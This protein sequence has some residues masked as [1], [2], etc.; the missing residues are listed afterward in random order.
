MIPILGRP[1][2]VATNSGGVLPFVCGGSTGDRAKSAWQ[3]PGAPNV[4]FHLE[5]MQKH[6]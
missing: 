1:A 6:L 2:A 3:R 5:G 4:A